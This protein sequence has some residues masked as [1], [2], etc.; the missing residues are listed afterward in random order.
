M[1][2]RTADWRWAGASFPIRRPTGNAPGQ[3]HWRHYV[4]SPWGERLLA[5]LVAHGYEEPDM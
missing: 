3:H 2:P 4:G 5:V 1:P